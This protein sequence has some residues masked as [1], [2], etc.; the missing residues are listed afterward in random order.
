MQRLCWLVSAAL[1]GKGDSGIGAVKRALPAETSYGQIKVPDGLQKLELRLCHV[2]LSSQAW[3]IDTR[4]SASSPCQ[5]IQP[6]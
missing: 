5:M 4:H 3:D 1:Q 6:T 2:T